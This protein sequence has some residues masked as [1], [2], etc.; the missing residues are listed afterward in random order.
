MTVTAET[1]GGELAESLLQNV[2]NEQVCAATRL[3][4][5]HRNGY[6]LRLVVYATYDVVST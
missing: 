1:T 2:G 5:A 4:G 3:F 6:W